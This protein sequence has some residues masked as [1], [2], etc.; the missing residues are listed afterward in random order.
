M[1]H[2]NDYPKE[3]GTYG[4]VG[5]ED[6]S[7]PRTQVQWKRH[8]KGTEDHQFYSPEEVSRKGTTLRTLVSIY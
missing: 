2:G 4:G 7:R 1:G 6:L 8:S 5:R 3:D